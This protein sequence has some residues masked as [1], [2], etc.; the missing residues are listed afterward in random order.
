MKQWSPSPNGWKTSGRQGSP[1]AEQRWAERDHLFLQS[2]CS[3]YKGYETPSVAETTEELVKPS[4]RLVGRNAPLAR[5]SAGSSGSDIA[6]YDL[7]SAECEEEKQDPPAAA[8]LTQEDVFKGVS[9][10]TPTVAGI[11]SAQVPSGTYASDPVLKEASR[12]GSLEQ[13]STPPVSA[14]TSV[15]GST[16]SSSSFQAT[17]APL[18]GINETRLRVPRPVAGSKATTVLRGPHREGKDRAAAAG[19]AGARADQP[20]REPARPADIKDALV[21]AQGWALWGTEGVCEAQ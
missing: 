15:G 21:R 19:E 11:A 1:E 13:P 20:T 17:D 12:A 2:N 16:P 10:L 14:T 6:A 18:N 9:L 4:Y 3:Q 8:G 7:V 5:G